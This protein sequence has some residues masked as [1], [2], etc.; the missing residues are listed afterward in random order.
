MCVEWLKANGHPVP[1]LSP[2]GPV[3]FELLQAD[4]CIAT[5]AWGDVWLVPAPTG[6]ARVEI[7]LKHL[8]LIEQI[9]RVF[10]GAQLSGLW[11]PAPT[12]PRREE[13]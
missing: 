5:E 3:P 13:P 9:T 6:R 11:M 10:P 1:A 4:V 8:A 7:T 12:S 2:K